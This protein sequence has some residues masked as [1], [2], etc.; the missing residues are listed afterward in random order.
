MGTSLIGWLSAAVLLVTLIIQVHAQWR[1]RSTAAVS[2]WLFAGQAL[3]YSGLIVYSALVRD[4]VFIATCS[5]IL[6]AVVIAQLLAY[7][8]RRRDRRRQPSRV[9]VRIS[10]RQ[11]RSGRARDGTRVH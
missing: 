6:L 5:L 2:H 9:V 1:E 11:F 8:G 10:R 3:A 7:G 4:V